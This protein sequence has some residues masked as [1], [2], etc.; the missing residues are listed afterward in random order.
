[1]M[2]RGLQLQ[3]ETAQQKKKAL[4]A[5]LLVAAE[6]AEDADARVRPAVRASGIPEMNAVFMRQAG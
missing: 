6:G 1:M 2:L 4:I 5:Q 3:D